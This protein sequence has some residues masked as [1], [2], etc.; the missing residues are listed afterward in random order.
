[1]SHIDFTNP[2]LYRSLQKSLKPKQNKV[3]T[4]LEEVILAILLMFSMF[5]VGYVL[6]QNPHILGI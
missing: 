6:Y 1:M 5:A 4:L 2:K 3:G